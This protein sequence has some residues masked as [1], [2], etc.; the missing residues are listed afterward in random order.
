MFFCFF[1]LSPN[2]RLR[3]QVIAFRPASFY[4]Y[5]QLFIYAVLRVHVDTAGSFLL[6]FDHAFRR[7]G[8]DRRVGG[9]I[10]DRAVFLHLSPC[11]F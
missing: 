4:N 7:N 9:L 3:S 1:L 10:L 8:G 2:F 5:L 6:C 11:G